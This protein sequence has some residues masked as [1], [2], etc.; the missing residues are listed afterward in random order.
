MAPAGGP[1]P[2]TSQ[3]PKPERPHK[4]TPTNTEIEK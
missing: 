2:Q 4:T 1:G 3:T